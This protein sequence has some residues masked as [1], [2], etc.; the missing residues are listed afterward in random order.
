MSNITD[1]PNHKK[2][3]TEGEQMDTSTV[4]PPSLKRAASKQGILANWEDDL[5]VSV[6]LISINRTRVVS[7]APGREV[8]YLKNLA[9]E[10]QGEG[11]ASLDGGFFDRVVLDQFMS[12]QVQ[13]R[14]V[15]YLIECFRRAVA[16]GK[17]NPPRERGKSP[18][19]LEE[20][21]NAAL[22]YFF[23][24]NLFSI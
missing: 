11:K 13:E 21:R 12:E 3:K 2:A 14:P 17:S 10:L 24:L 4:T 7:P 16:A 18:K 6:F 1:S 22:R 23:T 5:L 19:E 15:L 8:T 20:E 9:E